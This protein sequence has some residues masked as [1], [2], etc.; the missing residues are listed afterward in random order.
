M[1]N[2]QSFMA[3]VEAFHLFAIGGIS[4]LNPA[5]DAGLLIVIGKCFSTIAY[6][7]LIAESCLALKVA[8]GTLSVMFHGL[9]ED[10]STESLKLSAMFPANSA[11]RAQL[12]DI[13]QV[14]ETS[15]ADLES[16]SEFIAA[17]YGTEG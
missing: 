8:S 9:I 10:L 4:A 17:R 7:Q 13:V 12:Q 15:A 11:E 6:A 14:P 16:V 2:V 1:A 5:T 3:Q